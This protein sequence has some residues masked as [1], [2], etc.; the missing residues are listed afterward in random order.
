LESENQGRGILQQEALSIPP[1]YPAPNLPLEEV[2]G[3]TLALYGV[4]GDLKNFRSDRDQIV[5][6]NGGRDHQ[7]ILRISGEGEPVA[8]LEFQNAA[9]AHVKRRDPTLPIPSCLPSRNGKQL[10]LI[11]RGGVRHGVR[12]MTY[13]PGAP[14]VG[15]SRSKTLRRDIGA[16]LARLD[17]ALKGLD[18]PPPHD[19]LLW[20]IQKAATLSQLSRFIAD[21]DGR[22]LVERVFDEMV[23]SVLPKLKSF[24]QQTIHNDYNQ[25]N[26]LVDAADPDRVSGIIDF[27]DMVSGARVVDLGVAVARHLEAESPLEG[28]CFIVEGYN[29][30]AP[31]SNSERSVLFVLICA[32]L[33]IRS[34]IFSWRHSLGDTR[35]NL[36][37]VRSS[38]Q[39]LDALY[40][41]AP[42]D[43]E[44]TFARI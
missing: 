10:E 39:F 9:L 1:D 41:E 30:V 29:A 8:A 17:L 11:V 20:D 3:I 32:R 42:K 24:E 22:R 14:T 16:Q 26:V 4:T 23:S 18:T 43:T 5:Y 21:A 12:L 44:T 28:A 34:V 35:A 40:R 37:E 15:M 13:M 7:R 33:A 19:N 27:G 6:L 2:R 25:K 31:L 36:E 38:L